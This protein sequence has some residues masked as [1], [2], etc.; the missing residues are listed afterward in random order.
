MKQ[1]RE[2]DVEKPKK[3]N[4]VKSRE[5]SKPDAGK[6]RVVNQPE[7]IFLPEDTEPK[8]S[9][10]NKAGRKSERNNIIES[11]SHLGPLDVDPD[12]IAWE[13]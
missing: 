9:S 5:E 13:R 3:Q 6:P 2:S 1:K 10:A 7:E 8:K 12:T 11:E 4:Q